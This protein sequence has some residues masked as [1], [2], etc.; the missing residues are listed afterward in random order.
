[1]KLKQ[2]LEN[3]SFTLVNDVKDLDK[4]IKSGYISDLL[5]WVMGHA[6]QNC[7]WITI[8]THIN[9]IAVATLLEMAC[10]IVPEGENIDEDTIAK[11]T[12]EGIALISTDLT[13][14]KVAGVLIENGVK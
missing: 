6:E 11:A 10:I 5:S 14:Y 4:E 13:S 2:L 7:A 9:V 12:E 1:M 3:K 8:Q